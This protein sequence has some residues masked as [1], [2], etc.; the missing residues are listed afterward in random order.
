MALNSVVQ[1]TRRA[2]EAVC[3][4]LAAVCA[5]ALMGI[6]SQHSVHTALDVAGVTEHAGW[7]LQTLHKQ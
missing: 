4:G 6:G 7:E 5:I 3:V 2:W 1:A